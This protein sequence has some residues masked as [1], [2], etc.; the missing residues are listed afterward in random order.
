M[1]CLREL[2]GHGI[3]AINHGPYSEDKGASWMLQRKTAAKVF[4]N[5]N[6][7]NLMLKTFSEHAL[8]TCNEIDQQL[9]TDGTGIVEMQRL[10]YKFTLSSIG[11]IGFGVDIES[12]SGGS[13]DFSN[14]FDQAQFYSSQRFI[15]PF[16][17]V[18]ILG[19]LLYKGE[20]ELPKNIDM[21]NSYIYKIITLRKQEV[22]QGTGDTGDILTLF[23]QEKLNLTD[24]ELRDVVF[25]FLIAGRDTTAC[26]LSFAIM[27]LAQNPDWQE[28][29]RKE[30]RQV[31]GS[32]EDRALNSN[33]ISQMKLLQNIVMETLRLYPPVPVDI[34]EAAVDD[35]LPQGQLIPKGSRMTYEPYVMGR[36]EKFWGEESEKF[37]PDRWLKM[38]T[39]PS[40]YEFPQFQ[41]G[42]RICL[43]ETLAKFEAALFLG[44]LVDRYKLSCEDLNQVFTYQPGVTLS[45]KGGL[46][47]RVTKL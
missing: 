6:F 45:I 30:I 14:V 11:K 32:R 3:F 23:L 17:N 4:T 20:R 7:K 5:N 27:L 15:S 34:K 47:L 43:G 18:P 37:N 38:K 12:L 2:L 21:L 26:T 10:M 33:E 44:V 16:W 36:L 29:L 22:K 41:A 19:K 13:D 8:R 46:H 9:N 40:P 1:L 31:L 42:P 35:R 39:L 24:S 28:K 25:S